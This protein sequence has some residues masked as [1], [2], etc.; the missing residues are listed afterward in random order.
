MK[1][2]YFCST[3]Y[4]DFHNVVQELRNDLGE[5]FPVSIQ[6]W[7]GIGSRP[8]PLNIWKIYL[9]KDMRGNELGLFSYYQQNGDPD[10]QYWIGWIGVTP[11]FRRLGIAS[12][13]LKILEEE[14]V[15]LGARELLV[16]TDRE[17]NDAINLY[18]KHGMS[19]WGCF[20]ETNSEQA[21]ANDDSIVL[22]KKL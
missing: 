13:F 15:S 11:R 7:C 3:R 6:N 14:V 10:Y 22:M 20:R 17:N 1:L 19:E 9:A 4:S 18:I 16:Y 5:R 8:Y 21:A 12:Q 2:K